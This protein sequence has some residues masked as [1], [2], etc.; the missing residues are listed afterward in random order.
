MP[1]HPPSLFS[2][3]IVDRPDFAKTPFL[4]KG[5][6]SERVRARVGVKGGVVLKMARH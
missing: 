3:T 2:V 1:A 5:K 4:E 6:I